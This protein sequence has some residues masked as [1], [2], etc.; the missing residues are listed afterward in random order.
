M[1]EHP[2]HHEPPPPPRSAMH[3]P[4]SPASSA[5]EQAQH[6]LREMRE[7]RIADLD[8]ALQRLD[9]ERRR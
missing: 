1:T 2:V 9:E 4:P 3:L 6:H 8:T 5:L 7:E